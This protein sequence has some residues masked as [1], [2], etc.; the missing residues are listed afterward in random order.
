MRL[1]SF[2][3]ILLRKL[4][5]TTCSFLGRKIPPPKKNEHSN[6]NHREEEQ[7]KTGDGNIQPP[8]PH[9]HP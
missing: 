5:Y 4:G 1:E 7:K 3:E 8:I 9:T 6:L 2:H